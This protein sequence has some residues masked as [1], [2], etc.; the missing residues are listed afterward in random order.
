MKQDLVGY[1]LGALDPV[2]MER[3]EQQLIDNPELRQELERIGHALRP[4]ADHAAEVDAPQ[5]LA[6]RTV[7]HVQQHGMLEPWSG[8]RSSWRLTDL[9]V[10]ATILVL[11]SVVIFPALD[12]ARQQRQVTECSNNLR[13]LG[14]AMEGYAQSHSRYFPFFSATGPASVVGMTVPLL[15]EPGWVSDPSTFICPGSHDDPASI[16]QPARVRDAL[17]EMDRLNSMISSMGG[18]YAYTLGVRLRDVYY[19]PRREPMSVRCLAGDRPSR[20]DECDVSRS[21][22]PNHRGHG[23]NLLCPDGHVQFICSPTWPDDDNIYLSLR[24]RVEPGCTSFDTVIGSSETP[25]LGL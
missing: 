17:H 21:N 10:A 15:L 5:G 7:R 24:H 3:V 1:L 11:I 16:P 12:Q 18:S 8:T 25:Q 23:Q 22:S 9:A 19:A 13:N 20:L 14:V 2:E 4:L 6:E